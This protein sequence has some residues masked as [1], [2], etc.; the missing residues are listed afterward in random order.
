VRGAL[1]SFLARGK[2][3]TLRQIVTGSGLTSNVELCGT[4]EEV[5]DEMGEIMKQ[6]GG[7]GFLITS[8]VMRLNRATHRDHRRSDPGAAET[9]PRPLRVHRHDASRPLA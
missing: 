7:G 2:G 5:A 3:K 4:P 6:V 9:R 1:E 8:P